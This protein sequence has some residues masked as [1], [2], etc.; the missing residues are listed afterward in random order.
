[1]NR[2]LPYGG[3]GALVVLAIGVTAAA[4]VA[5]PP[6]AAAQCS[7][8]SR[9]PCAFASYPRYYPCGLHAGGGCMS[10]SLLPLNQVPVIHVTGHSGPP[11]PIDRDK[12]ANRLNE[13][14]PILSKCL[15]LPPDNEIRTGMRVTLK[16]AFKRDGELLGTPRFTYITHEAPDDVKAAYHDAAINM[17]N[18]CM[19]LPITASLGGAIAGRPFVIPIIETREPGH[20]DAP[21]EPKP[22]EPANGPKANDTQDG[23]KP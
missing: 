9:H 20:A 19:P 1:M 22:A 16:L 14:G 6:E 13:M 10:N 15:Q 8:L 23:T 11:E 12:P 5:V 21:A 4:T 3:A 18:H 2:A 17:L 7:V